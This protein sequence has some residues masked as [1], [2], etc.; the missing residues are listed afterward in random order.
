M[1][2]RN[3]KMYES[4]GWSPSEPQQQITVLDTSEA[5]KF[6]RIAALRPELKKQI[7][8]WLAPNI[9]DANQRPYK[10]NA[11]FHSAYNCNSG[12]PGNIH[13]LRSARSSGIPWSHLH[14]PPCYCSIIS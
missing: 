10:C 6:V 11:Y 8:I 13:R 1:E 12:S 9:L 7:Q 3:D 14:G 4:I 2:K 5:G